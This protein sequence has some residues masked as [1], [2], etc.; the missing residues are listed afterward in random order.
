MGL[1][2]TRRL[3]VTPLMVVVIPGLVGWMEMASKASGAA[4]VVANGAVFCAKASGTTAKSVSRVAPSVVGSVDWVHEFHT[5][6][7][8]LHWVSMWL[9]LPEMSCRLFGKFERPPAAG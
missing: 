1:V 7:S 8:T 9:E 3:V 6:N 4:G 2:Q 5:G